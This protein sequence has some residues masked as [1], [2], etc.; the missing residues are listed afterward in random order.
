[1][2]H[3][4]HRGFEFVRLGPGPIFVPACHVVF[5]GA[6]ARIDSRCGLGDLAGM[7]ACASFGEDGFAAL[8]LRCVFSEIRGAAG[9]SFNR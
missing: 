4:A 6:A 7:A 2:D 5:A 9:A 8:Q 1:M 3:L